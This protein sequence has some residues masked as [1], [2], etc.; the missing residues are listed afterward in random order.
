MLKAISILSLQLLTLQAFA[1]DLSSFNKYF[2]LVRDEAGHVQ[3]V[4]MNFVQEKVSLAPYLKQVTEDLKKEIELLRTKHGHEEL[5]KLLADLQEGSEKTYEV[6]ESIHTLRDSFDHLRNVSID[7]FLEPAKGQGVLNYFRTELEKALSFIDLSILANTNDARFFYK[8]HV[9]SEILK[10][11]LNLAKKRFDSVPVLNL[12]SFIMVEV[13]EM[14]LEQ[15]H[16]YQN[17]LL[18]YLENIDESKMGLGRDEADRIFSSIYESR[19]GLIN[20]MESN[21]AVKTWQR[22]GLNKFYAK[23]RVANNKLRRSTR[24]FQEVGARLNFAFFVARENNELVIKNLFHTK[25]RFSGEMA[26]AYSFER[27]SRVKRFRALLNIG[28]LGLGF[29]PIPSWLKGQVESFVDSYY[30]E[31][32]KLEGSLVAYFDLAGNSFM[33]AK[34][35]EQ[36]INPYILKE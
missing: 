27:P 4:K 29:L 20:V 10:R 22:Y 33:A 1:Q 12:V 5:E 14:I 34:I 7:Q 18:H 11:A 8:R 13:H 30:K 35:R 6:D 24:N 23:V 3:Y 36:M 21:L 26:T 2:K 31:Q 25:H 15:R 17:M 9:S 16:F 19:I 28:K 32:K